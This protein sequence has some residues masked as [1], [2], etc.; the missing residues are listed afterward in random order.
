MFDIKNLAEHVP[1]LF[2]LSFS[3][4]TNFLGDALGCK[5]QN[6][7]SNNMLLKYVIIFFVIYSSMSLLDKNTTPGEHFVKSLYIMILFLLFTKNT[8]R[9]TGIIG[10]CMILLFIIE[11]YKN[12]Y[13]KQNDKENE[14]KFNKLSSYIKYIILILIIYGHI[15]YLVKKANKFKGEFD[16]FKLY[17]GTKCTII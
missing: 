6:L 13:N 4:L 3:I 14:K 17:K 10:I 1:F 15:V 7:F 11:D 9:M 8:L 5:I 16:L 12:Y 2:I